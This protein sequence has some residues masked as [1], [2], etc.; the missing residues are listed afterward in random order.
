[1][2]TKGGWEKRRA[3]C[4]QCG[5]A[6]AKLADKAEQTVSGGAASIAAAQA[7]QAEEEEALK[8]AQAS[9][10]MMDKLLAQLHQRKADLLQ[11][12]AAIFAD[13]ETQRGALSE[14]LKSRLD[15]ARG[16]P[17]GGGGGEESPF[18]EHARL[19]AELLHLAEEFDAS[20]A[21]HKALL[22]E[23]AASAAAMEAE[24]ER[25]QGEVAASEAEGARLRAHMDAIC[26]GEDATAAALKE[27]TARFGSFNESSRASSGQFSERAQAFNAAT[28]RARAAE[29]EVRKLKLVK[30]GQT[31]EL[32]ALKERA[33]AKEAELE[34]A[35]EKTAKMRSLCDTL[36]EEIELKPL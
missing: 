21:S 14:Q 24:L 35:Q 28:E 15:G 22:A 34:R 10:A 17:T 33:A 7:K 25:V 32:K 9:A 1:M 31:K 36:R 3:A 18:E 6:F 12:R 27:F 8:K 26:E 20:E 23:S 2:Q 30:A 16:A 29:L 5:D 19:R 11:E 4:D 13:D